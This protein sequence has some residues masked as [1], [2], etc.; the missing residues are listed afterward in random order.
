MEN[1]K[2]L[3]HPAENMKFQAELT[4]LTSYCTLR[5]LQIQQ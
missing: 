1:V 4:K 3:S 2:Q 5:P